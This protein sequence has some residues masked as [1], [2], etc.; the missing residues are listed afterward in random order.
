MVN[1]SANANITRKTTAAVSTRFRFRV[2]LGS[3]MPGGAGG[4]VRGDEE[5]F[6]A[7][8]SAVIGGLEGVRPPITVEASCAA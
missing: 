7:R 4:G 1:I 6:S 2:G 3:R 5:A 8:F